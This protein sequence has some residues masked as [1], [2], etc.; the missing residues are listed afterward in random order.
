MVTMSVAVN[1][2]IWRGSRLGPRVAEATAM[3]R[4]AASLLEEQ[5][6]ETRSEL[7]RQLAI[8]RQQRASAALYHSTLIPQTEA[9]YDSTLSAYR[10]GRS[11][12]PALLQARMRVYEAR[13]GAA[14]AVAEHNKAIAEIDLLTGRSAASPDPEG[15][16]R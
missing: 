2:P 13:I 16:L 10:L 1:L 9:A 12:F 15:A 5:Q 14:G 3:R 8:E 7:E 6:L 4:Q 11:D